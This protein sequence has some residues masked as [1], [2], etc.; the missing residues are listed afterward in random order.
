[1]QNIQTSPEKPAAKPYIQK[2]KGLKKENK[3]KVL[4]DIMS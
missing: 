4:T 3:R 1:M 2:E